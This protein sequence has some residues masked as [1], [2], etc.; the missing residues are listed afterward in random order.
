[1]DAVGDESSQN[2]LRVVLYGR[3]GC[4]LCEEA[5]AVVQR[6]QKT[7]P[8]ELT[9]VNIQA[10]EALYEKMIEIIPVVEAGGEPFSQF[11]VD[12][13]LF[14]NKLKELKH[15][16]EFALKRSAGRGSV[17]RSVTAPMRKRPSP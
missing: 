12:E 17:Q 4:H 16:C 2:A 13:A 11:F 1:M 9:I 3:P 6:V 14:R 5:L 8:F 7:E 10:D 15:S